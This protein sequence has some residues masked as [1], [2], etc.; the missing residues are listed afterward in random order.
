V[1]GILIAL[2][3]N[4]WNEERKKKGLE[5]STLLELKAALSSDAKTL[6]GWIL[7][8]VEYNSNSKVLL[9][10]IK[11]KSPYSNALDTIWQKTVRYSLFHI[12]N[13]GFNLM[14]HRGSDL[15]SNEALRKAIVYHYVNDQQELEKDVDINKLFS[16]RYINYM[17]DHLYNPISKDFEEEFNMFNEVLLPVDYDTWISSPELQV[18]LSHSIKRRHRMN[19]L[20][21][22]H[23][24]KTKKLLSKIENELLLL[25]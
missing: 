8:H 25:E 17:F 7:A 10:H 24:Q 23:L 12:D 11:A 20:A 3:I 13:S 18:K 15:I 4:S 2:Q 21:G 19:I 16:D 6:E 1:I 9:E 5:R 22:G 14:E